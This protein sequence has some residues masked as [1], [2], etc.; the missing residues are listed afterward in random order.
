MT[1]MKSVVINNFQSI[2]SITL[3]FPERESGGSITTVVGPSSSGKSAVLRALYMWAHNVASPP[4]R[5]G[6]KKTRVEVNLGTHTVSV[7]RGKAL[8][9]YWI[10]DDKHAK[11]GTTVPQA[12]QSLVK[13][14]REGPD[15]HL[16]TQF[17]KP[18]LLNETG[19][20]LATVFGRL[21]HAHILREA[22]REG[23]RRSQS[24]K[25]TA[26]AQQEN[27]QAIMADLQ[28]RFADLPAQREAITAADK[29]LQQAVTAQR[30]ADTVSTAYQS[31]Q[32]A[33]SRA[34]QAK[35]VMDT[36]PD[37]KEA[38]RD[39]GDGLTGIGQIAHFAA[40]A[41][42]AAQR[43]QIAQRSLV[44]LPDASTP[45]QDAGAALERAR[46]ID[47]AVT[48]AQTAAVREAAVRQVL[49]TTPDAAAPLGSA[50][51]TLAKMTDIEV[52][53]FHVRDAAEAADQCRKNRDAAH[54]GA[55]KFS[56]EYH[57]VLHEMDVCPTCLQSLESV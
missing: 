18:F 29:A 54:G 3:D 33:L 17:D 42:A 50:R 56:Q 13:M 57:D 1:V 49:D 10:D 39:A 19:S 25:H 11:A 35:Q 7:E 20:S 5:A 15:L 34:Q 46:A 27:A 16:A 14:T 8:S 23:A 21:T 32:Q 55:E 43:M 40:A 31:A 37:A 22:V 51:R 12:V 53:L 41:H 45:L 2:A 4:V 52:A 30:T 24:A 9:T 6:A 48:Q 36:T 26:Q 47:A 44:D 38:L 28:A